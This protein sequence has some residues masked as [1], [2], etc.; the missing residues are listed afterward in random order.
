MQ[1]INAERYCMPT[2]PEQASC[3]VSFALETFGDRWTLLV[4][5]DVMLEARYRYRELLA[6]NP[7]IAT[8]ILAD[9]LKRLEQRGLI[10]K[11]R[12]SADARQFIYKPT[13]LAVSLI[14]M[15]VEMMVW[16]ARHGN[17]AIDEHF[18]SR[19][20]TEREQLIRQLQQKARADAGL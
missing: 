2:T 5:R 20:D 1:A 8:N 3:P 11:Q 16:G 14:P 12:D 15:L 6:A 19:F 10:S 9:R 13:Y 18:L 17:G 7:G 4:L